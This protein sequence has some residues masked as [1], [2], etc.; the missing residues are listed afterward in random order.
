MSKNLFT[1]KQFLRQ[2]IIFLIQIVLEFD[3][4][5]ESF[6]FTKFRNYVTFSF[7]FSFSL[8]SPRSIQTR[9]WQ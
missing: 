9:L 2:D 3:L 5:S 6:R 1:K 7:A 8:M 4:F